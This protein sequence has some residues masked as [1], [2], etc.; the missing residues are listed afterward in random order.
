MTR[1][2]DLDASKVQRFLAD[3]REQ[4]R[5]IVEL[6]P[7]KEQYTKNELAA[8]LG[9]GLDGLT[10][11]IARHRLPATGLGKARRFPRQTAEA[12]RDRLGR[13]PGMQTANHYLA[14]IKSFTRWLVQRGR[15]AK[16]PLEILRGGNV[17]KDLRH[18]R[19]TLPQSDLRRLFQATGASTR[20]FRG[21]TGMDRLVLY[22]TAAGTGFR[23]GELAVLGPEC[24]DLDA[25]PPVVVLPARE[26]KAGRSVS[27]PLPPGLV[28][29]LRD[30]LA[31]R[32][33][34]QAVWP[35]S[36]APAA[37]PR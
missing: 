2:V 15:L 29:A 22:L 19:R 7:R 11:L 30:Y 8:V 12:L 18:D 21:L 4:G 13:P 33:R 24:F 10:S 34:G 1:L 20:T 25:A 28:V 14:A 27:Q 37:P 26:D 16:N 17:R 31:D 6:D 5:P 36:S 23:A 32:P 9:V 35:G 3:L